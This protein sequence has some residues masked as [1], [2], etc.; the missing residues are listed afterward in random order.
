MRGAGRPIG[1]RA[2]QLL[3]RASGSF[4][5]AASAAFGTGNHDPDLLALRAEALLRAGRKD[6]A[7]PLLE[8]LARQN[9][10]YAELDE[11]RTGTVR[12]QDAR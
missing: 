9:V 8:E 4:A 12:Q 5:N 10:A 7:A 2:P 6:D 3:R 11:L 1:S